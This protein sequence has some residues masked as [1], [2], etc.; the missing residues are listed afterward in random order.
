MG[1][2]ESA[3]PSGW[4]TGRPTCPGGDTMA[5]VLLGS[6]LTLHEQTKGP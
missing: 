2:E 1:G 4:E 3:E 5:G 6:S